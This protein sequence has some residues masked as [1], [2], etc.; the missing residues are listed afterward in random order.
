[1]L[2]RPLELLLKP[3]L[4]HYPIPDR[5]F[6]LTQWSLPGSQSLAL[7]AIEAENQMIGEGCHLGGPD[8]NP[9]YHPLTY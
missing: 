6:L 1:M 7:F 2:R 3:K 8:P 5:A 4:R 9:R